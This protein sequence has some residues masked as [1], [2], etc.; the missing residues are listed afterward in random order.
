MI[1]SPSQNGDL[2]FTPAL[3]RRHKMEL[4]AKWSIETRAAPVDGR[5]SRA[6]RAGPQTTTADCDHETVQNWSLIRAGICS[7]PD[8]TNQDAG[9]SIAVDVGEREYTAPDIR[10]DRVWLRNGLN[11]TS[12]ERRL[13]KADNLV[14]TIFISHDSHA[15][16]S[17]SRQVLNRRGIV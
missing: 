12:K 10:G 1:S 5:V 2:L 16:V 11:K 14:F 9:Y 17:E 3:H 6:H 7:G 8:H 13:V 4:S 15:A